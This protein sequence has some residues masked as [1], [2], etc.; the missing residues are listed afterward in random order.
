M[1]LTSVVSKLLETLI[2]DHMVEFLVKHKLINTSQHGFLKARSCLTNLLCFL[3]EITKWV[4]DGSPVDVVYLDFQK[5]FDKVSHQRLLLKLNA[6]GVINWIEKWLI[7]R[8]Q[9]VIVDGEISNWKLVLSGVP[10]G[11]VLGPKLF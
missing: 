6:H 11:S 1:S 8:R 9:R 5:A 7:H 2:T 10:Q 4:D 3:E